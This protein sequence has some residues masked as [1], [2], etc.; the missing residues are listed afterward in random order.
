MI[1]GLHPS[2]FAII[3]PAWFGVFSGRRI[4]FEFA[5]RASMAGFTT[6]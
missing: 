5:R 6:V 3:P 4:G 2:L 1:H